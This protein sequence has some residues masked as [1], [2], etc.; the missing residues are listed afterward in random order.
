M[1]D[2]GGDRGEDENLNQSELAEA[3]EQK[4]RERVADAFQNSAPER[5]MPGR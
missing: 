4:N 3:T 5:M 2:H 1:P